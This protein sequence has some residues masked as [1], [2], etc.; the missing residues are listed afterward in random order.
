MQSER[1]HVITVPCSLI[2]IICACWVAWLRKIDLVHQSETK[3]RYIE[4]ERLC[5][6]HSLARVGNVDGHLNTGALLVQS[7]HQAGQKIN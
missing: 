6:T 4:E 7:L 2:K 1:I 3:H 5:T